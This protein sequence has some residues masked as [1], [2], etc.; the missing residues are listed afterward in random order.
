MKAERSR[1]AANASLAG[2]GGRPEGLSKPLPQ[3]ALSSTRVKRRRH[4][5]SSPVK[6]LLDGALCNFNDLPGKSLTPAL[7]PELERPTPL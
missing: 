5:S 3:P 6:A 2:G 7:Q 4:V 1:R